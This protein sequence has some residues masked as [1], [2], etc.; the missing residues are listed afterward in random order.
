MDMEVQ[1]VIL[2][3][4]LERGLHP[5][6]GQD[7]SAELDKACAQVAMI[8]GERAAEAKQ[9]S[10]WVVRISNILVDLGILPAQ[11]I[12]Q[13]LMSAREVLPV[14]DLILKRLQEVLAS[15]AG[16]WD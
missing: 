2:A 10:Q 16:P 8:N 12:P 11:D 5:T 9:L 6:N 14:V 3:E 15:S 1:E 4:E 7:L 13:L